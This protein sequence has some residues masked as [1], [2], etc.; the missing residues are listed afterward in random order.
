[1]ILSGVWKGSTA[2]VT[3]QGPEIVNKYWVAISGANKASGS[4]WAITPA[5]CIYATGIPQLNAP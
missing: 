3:S 2:S 4:G 1:M 5:L